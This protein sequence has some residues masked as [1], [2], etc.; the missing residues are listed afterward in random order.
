MECKLISKHLFCATSL[1]LF[2]YSATLLGL[3]DINIM[4]S[5]ISDRGPYIYCIKP[6]LLGLYPQIWTYTTVYSKKLVVPLRIYFVLTVPDAVVSVM[7]N[8]SQKPQRTYP[9]YL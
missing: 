9:I 5:L 4:H 1:H 8:P 6:D 7:E 2:S 3:A